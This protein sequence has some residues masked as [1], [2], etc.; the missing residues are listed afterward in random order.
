MAGV[1]LV[2]APTTDRWPANSSTSVISCVWRPG[3]G[4]GR[5]C[6]SKLRTL[7]TE[8][9]GVEVDGGCEGLRCSGQPL[10]RCSG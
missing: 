8:M 6:G 1:V 2:D 3:E 5:S 7:P 9:A 4:S 10:T